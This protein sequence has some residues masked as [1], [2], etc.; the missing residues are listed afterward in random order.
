M[1]QANDADGRAHALVTGANRGIGLEVARGLVRA[2]RPAIVLCRR[3]AEVTRTVDLLAEEGAAPALGVACDLSEPDAIQRTCADLLARRTRL[4]SIVRNAGVYSQSLERT[5]AGVERT[6]AV[7]VLAPFLLTQHL[8]PLMSAGA[9]IVQLA[10]IYHLRGTL[11]F[12]DLQFERRPS[13]AT[14]ANAQA[15]L[16]RV[17]LA[18]EWSRRFAERDVT[19]VAVHPGPVMTDAIRSAPWAMQVLAHTLARPAFHSPERG[20]APVVATCTTP[21]MVTGAFFRRDEL[22]A[23]I[24]AAH[25]LDVARR[26]WAACEALCPA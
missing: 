2:G 15:Q 14:V 20:A 6:F 22:R 3:P 10:G 9:R 1:E 11:D 5:A 17:V 12:E 4:A 21:S 26:L 16:A 18:M 13:D 24:P 8:A 23:S 7:D 25:D 19:A